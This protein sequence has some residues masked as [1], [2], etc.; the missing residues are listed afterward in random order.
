MGKKLE[1]TNANGDKKT[2]ELFYRRGGEE[3]I[4]D[5][6]GFNQNFGVVLTHERSPFQQGGTT[7]A[8]R[9]DTRP[10]SFVI[11][12]LRPTQQELEERVTNIVEFMNPYLGEVTIVHDNGVRRRRISAYYA[13]HSFVS[14]EDNRGY[15]TLAI[16][17][18]SDSA[19]FEDEFTQTVEMGTGVDVFVLPMYIPFEFGTDVEHVLIENTG[20]YYNYVEMVLYGPLVDPKLIRDVYEGSTITKT[21]VIEFENFNIPVDCELRIRTEQG[22]EEATLVSPEGIETNANRYLSVASNYW[23]LFVGTNVIRFATDSGYPYTQI[24]FR[25]KYIVA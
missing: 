19:L 11:H 12:V 24:S 8:V 9:G 3:A 22:R 4:T 1:M 13:G 7:V 16:D 17:L 23:Q 6:T 5:L 25:R 10:L 18:M 21:D 14:Y 15:G 20:D 2:F